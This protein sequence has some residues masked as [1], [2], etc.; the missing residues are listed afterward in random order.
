MSLL[1]MSGLMKTHT[2]ETNVENVLRFTAKEDHPIK[3]SV[4][5][6]NDG[7]GLYILDSITMWDEPAI[8][9]PHAKK[10]TWERLSGQ[11][12]K[13]EVACMSY[14]LTET[15]P[16]ATETLLLPESNPVETQVPGAMAYDHSPLMEQSYMD[17]VS[18]GE[19]YSI[20]TKRQIAQAAEVKTLKLGFKY[21]GRVP[22]LFQSIRLTT[23][24]AN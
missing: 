10:A 7:T 1:S 5:F 15:L 2:L 19:P 17:A 3:S 12:K 4:V 22:Y 13:I 8:Q 16:T 23:T 14:T 9:C 21:S 11:W 6:T 20:F 24:T 18:K